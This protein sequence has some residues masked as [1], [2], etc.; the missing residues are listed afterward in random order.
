VQVAIVGREQL[1]ES[2]ERC[3]PEGAEI[4]FDNILDR[5]TGSEDSIRSQSAYQVVFVTVLNAFR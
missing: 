3:N 2:Y 4:P 5:V 1:I